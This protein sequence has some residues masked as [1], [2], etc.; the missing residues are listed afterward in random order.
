MDIQASL[1]SFSTQPLLQASRAL[2]K[3]ALSIP[4]QPLADAAIEPKRFF[5]DQHKEDKHRTIRHLYLVGRIDDRCFQQAKSTGGDALDFD[6]TLAATTK[7]YDGMF[8]IAVE[9]AEGEFTRSDLASRTREINRVFTNPVIVVFKHLHQKQP[10]LS[11]GVISRREHKRTQGAHVLGKVS[12]IREIRPQSPHRGHIEILKDFSLA[13]LEKNAGKGKRG[14]KI[15]SF[16][17]FHAALEA[18]FDT[19]LLNKRFYKDLANWYF[20]ALP[21]V[22]FPDDMEKDDEKRRATGLIRLLTRLIFCWF[23]KEKDGLIPEKLFDSAELQKILKGFDPESETSSTYYQAILQNLFFATLNQR[24]GKDSKGNPHRVFAKDE[25]YPKNRTTY[26]VNNLYRYEKLFAVPEEEALALFADIP[27]LNGGLFECLDRTQD[28]TDKKLYLDGFSRNSKKRPH[29]PDRLFFDSGETADL[30]E[31][32]GDKKRKKEQVSGLISILNRYKFTIVENTPIDQEVA[33]DPELLGQIFEN[34]LASYNEETKTTARKQTGSFYTPRPIVNYM[35][36]ESLKAHFLRILV[37]KAGMTEA[38]ARAGLDLLFAYNEK[39]FEELGLPEEARHIL[40]AA[41]DDLK[42]LDPACGSG[43]FPMGVLHKLVYLLSKLDPENVE[44]EK[45]QIAKVQEITDTEERRKKL[46]EI[47][48]NFADNNDDYG[49]KLYLIENCLYG[50]D[51]QPIAIQI[52]KLRF[53]ISLVCDQKTNRNKK[54][55]HGIRPL[56]NLETKFVAADSLIGLPEMNQSVLVDPRVGTIEKEIESLYHSHFSEQNRTRKLSNQRKVKSLRE[57]LAKLLAESLMSPA[58]SKHV[59]EWDPFD[60]QLSADFFDPHWMFGHKLANGFDIIIGN[61][62]YIQIRDIPP[63][64]RRYFEENYK[65]AT[66]RFNL[67][68]LFIEIAANICCKEGFTSY[69]VPD[70]LL[71]NTQCKEIRKW[72]LEKQ[73]I[74][75]IVS[76]NDQVFDSAV[77]D[78]ILVIFQNTKMSRTEVAAKVKVPPQSISITDNRMIPLSYFQLSPSAQFDL[79]YTN[80]KHSLITKVAG[81]SVSLGAISDTK[82]GIIQSK[83]G[84][85]LF[86]T[87]RKNNLC[88]KLLIGKDVNPFVIS[89]EDRWVDYRPDEM[90]ALELVKGGN[91]LRLRNPSVFERQ[92]ILTRQTADCII[93]A[94]DTAN[95]YY[96]NTLHGT[97]IT[98]PGYNPLF[99]LAVLNSKITTW[100]YRSNTDEE[101]KVFAQIK[102]ELLRKLPVP[103]A[104]QQ[105]QEPLVNLVE[106]ILKAKASNPVADT[107]ALEH[108]IDQQVYNLYGLTPEEIAIVEGTA[109]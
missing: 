82:D 47:A 89:Y 41:I 72:L 66:G 49:R 22:E 31:V 11:I 76:F 109:P 68:Y 86:L 65:F 97:A 55:N 43:A 38:D 94:F 42:I 48:S 107:T 64:R 69:I 7:D 26:D 60:P 15:D 52:T 59:A 80:E 44:W 95:Y 73:T 18:V 35:V 13:E 4:L 14:H 54:D 79:N 106:K 71:L 62:P 8:V 81:V 21:Q 5:R 78:S 88:K 93:A 87:T 17:S 1:Q 103:K 12:M 23:L 75:E 2:F 16:K 9:M 96:A 37:E 63:A 36:D 101:G 46:A 108:E 40:I 30:S 24:M 51:I 19:D 67:F 50:V 58:K 6:A 53:F 70:R 61:P 28:V 29:V 77:V 104:S 33:L 98:D 45:L 27:F 105:E 84:D 56:P 85:D 100:F 57:E 102:I 92:K 74:S 3:D 39:P 20:W 32:Y 99:V 83:I 10:V 91:G 25:G 34:L 90:A